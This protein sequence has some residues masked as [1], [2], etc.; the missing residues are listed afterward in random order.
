MVR[1]T[2]RIP[3]T[4]AALH[5]L[6]CTST[7]TAIDADPVPLDATV[8]VKDLP[9]QVDDVGDFPD[10][11]DGAGAAG[12][13]LVVE[14]GI[15][16]WAGLSVPETD[17]V[18]S[19][20]R[21]GCH[22]IYLGRVTGVEGHLLRMEFRKVGDD[23]IGG[24]GPS[25]D[26][27]FW[28]VFQTEP[29]PS[30]FLTASY[31]V[32][33]A[34]TWAAKTILSTTVPAWPSAEAFAAADCGETRRVHIVTGGADDLESK[35]WFQGRSLLVTKKCSSDCMPDCTD[36]ACGADGCGGSCGECSGLCA[37]GV[38]EIVSMPAFKLGIAEPFAWNALGLAKQWQLN[39][40]LAAMKPLNPEIVRTWF[41][42]GHLWSAPGVV[43]EEKVAVY[44]SC[45][46]KLASAGYTIVGMDHGLPA[47]LTGVEAGAVPCRDLIP[48]SA[49]VAFLDRLEETWAWKAAR[50][51]V[52]GHWEVGNEPNLDVFLHPSISCDPDATFTFSEKV[53]VTVDMM[54]RASRGV[55]SGNPQAVV[56]MPGIAPNDEVNFL[57]AIYDR[58]AAG[59]APS[60]NPRDFFDGAA[61]HPYLS[62]SES[63]ASW[64]GRNAAMHGILATN[65]DSHIPV[66][67]SELGL[68]DSHDSTKWDGHADRLAALV[69]AAKRDMP[70]LWGLTWFRLFDDPTYPIGHPESGFGMLAS[71]PA[72]SQWKPAAFA[73]E[74]IRNNSVQPAET[75]CAA[76][77]TPP[78][79]AEQ[80]V[81]TNVEELR[82]VGG[83]LWGRARSTAGGTV[84]V[85]VGAGTDLAAIE[86]RMVLWG[87]GNVTAKLVDTEG[88]S[89][90]VPLANIGHQAEVP[91]P[92]LYRADISTLLPD[93]ATIV[94]VRLSFPAE[95]AFAVDSIRLLGQQ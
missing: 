15:G 8:D 71:P 61:W 38:C 24:A 94:R 85:P 82:T 23:Q 70:W 76:E 77:F 35:R 21:P 68:T 39:D 51:P 22:A 50:Y 88:G 60:T 32:L 45:V 29:E 78:G 48:D 59:D 14:E 67:L 72:G 54:F 47:W 17:C 9:P 53:A 73:F 40:Q 26:V 83:W 95:A 12:F 87:T 86:V 49:Y 42:M 4:L 34:G 81:G 19:A 31:P 56:F 20:D 58:I 30:C 7:S 52:I 43:N 69:A 41:D 10:I 2:R 74:S 27:P 13:S 65:G 5:A 55:K 33:S 1:S 46:E 79:D 44:D 93:G 89:W 57:A 63:T 91:L 92:I 90:A 36:R 84:D 75:A 3:F 37:D 6:S 25:A 64:L 11:D 16:E 80:P 28:V 66:L 62:G 18:C